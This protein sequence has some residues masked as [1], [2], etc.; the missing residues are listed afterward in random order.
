MKAERQMRGVKV[1]LRKIP[2]QGGEEGNRGIIDPEAGQEAHRSRQQEVGNEGSPGDQAGTPREGQELEDSP[3]PRAL[4]DADQSG[5]RSRQSGYARTR[6]RGQGSRPS[7][8]PAELRGRAPGRQQGRGGGPVHRSGGR[9]SRK[10]QPAGQ[11]QWRREGRA[12][13]GGPRS[14][15][16]LRK[17]I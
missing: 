2:S 8:S 14:G 16:P 15:G 12:P 4:T 17:G 11:Q 7:G 6:G 5:T 3:A 10:G 13:A 9:E 1:M